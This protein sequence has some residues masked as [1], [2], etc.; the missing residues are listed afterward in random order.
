MIHSTLFSNFEGRYNVTVDL[1]LLP[2]FYVDISLRKCEYSL[3]EG[4]KEALVV[5]QIS[6]NYFKATIKVIDPE[7][8]IKQVRMCLYHTL[9]SA[10]SLI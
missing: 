9:T 10:F 1:G 4:M 8:A 6:Q 2:V 5:T 7:S 3:T